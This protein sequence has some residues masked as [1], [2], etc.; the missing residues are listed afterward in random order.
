MRGL[1]NSLCF[2]F[3]IVCWG[4]I[5]WSCRDLPVVQWGC[6]AILVMAVVIVVWGI[7]GY[8]T[9]SPKK[10]KAEESTVR[11]TSESPEYKEDWS[12]K[13]M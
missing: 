4:F 6:G 5:L 1:A 11:K 10:P 8:Y 7:Q 9:P 3:G 2:L 12:G 13:G